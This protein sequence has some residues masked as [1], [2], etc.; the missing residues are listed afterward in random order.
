MSITRPSIKGVLVATAATAAIGMAAAFA[1]VPGASAASGGA[2]KP[3]AAGT[4]FSFNLKASSPAILSCLPG[5]GGHVTIT[6]QALNDKMVVSLHGMPANTAFD[7][8]VIQ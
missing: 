3:A 5:A 6:P 1:A 4:P 8:F 2:A 7:L